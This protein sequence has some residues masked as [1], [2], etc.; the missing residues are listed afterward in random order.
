MLKTQKRKKQCPAPLKKL[1]PYKQVHEIFVY[2]D[3]VQVK[4]VWLMMTLKFNH[5]TVKKIYF[6]DAN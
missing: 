6:S 5:L 2:A 1:S 3:A 4:P